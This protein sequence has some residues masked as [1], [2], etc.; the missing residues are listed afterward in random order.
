M[1]ISESDPFMIF[2]AG[3][4]RA[5]AL[6]E[7]RPTVT[8][9]F[10]ASMYRGLAMLAEMTGRTFALR[11]SDGRPKAG[12]AVAAP[13][14]TSAGRASGIAQTTSS[15]PHPTASSAEGNA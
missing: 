3:C 1:P 12:D 9:A 5:A 14:A 2:A 10:A 7:Q 6:Q 13:L 4:E 15:Y 11:D 8:P